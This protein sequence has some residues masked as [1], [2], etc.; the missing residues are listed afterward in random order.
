MGHNF[1]QDRGASFA[2]RRA[3]EHLRKAR[4][5]RTIVLF[6]YCFS[7]IVLQPPKPVHVCCC[8]ACAMAA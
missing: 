7:N 5:V 3:E 1:L 4:V 6:T 8:S 2:Q